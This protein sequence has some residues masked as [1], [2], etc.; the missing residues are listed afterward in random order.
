M[1]YN[2]IKERVAAAKSIAIFTHIIPDGDAISSACAVAYWL[3]Q[4][5]KNA[6]VYLQEKLCDEFGKLDINDLITYDTPQNIDLIIITDCAK[7][8]RVG[9]YEQMVKESKNCIVID[10]HTSFSEYAT[11]N[12][13]NTA[14]CSTCEF[15]YDIFSNIGVKI[16]KKM[17]ELLYL[18]II[19]DSGGF[20]HNNTT[21]NS[22]IVVAKLFE[23]GIDFDYINRRYMNTVSLKGI[24][25][26]KT[27]L[28]N[29]EFFIDNRLAVSTISVQELQKI[30]ANINDTGI[31]VNQILAIEPVEIAILATE[32]SENVYKVSIRS[33]FDIDVDMI[34]REFG[35]GG[36]SRA[37]GCQIYGTRKKILDELLRVIPTYLKG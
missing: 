13:L 12:F 20:M 26:L 33:K 19:R 9:I 8:E 2:I 15:L 21:A 36:H 4:I 29:L 30:G 25:V 28:N 14:S 35:G 31:I 27:A 16:D 22:H 37:S 34:A 7:S 10:H 17:A 32:V 11:Y 18:G 24:M 1:D 5:G 6:K 23:I 3:Q